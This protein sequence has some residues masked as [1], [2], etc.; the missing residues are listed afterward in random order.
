MFATDVTNYKKSYAR[1]LDLHRLMKSGIQA[2]KAHYFCLMQVEKY[3]AKLDPRVAK[4]VRSS[5]DKAFG[6]TK[7]GA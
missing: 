5:V 2:E 7:E 1:L 6:V 4:R 3:E